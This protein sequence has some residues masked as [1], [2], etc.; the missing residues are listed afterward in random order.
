M[1][2]TQFSSYLG[3][4]LIIENLSDVETEAMQYLKTNGIRFHQ[5]T[6]RWVDR[7]HYLNTPNVKQG[8]LK[9]LMIEC[10]F[11]ERWSKESEL[12]TSGKTFSHIFGL[13]SSPTHTLMIK[14]NIPG[15]CW[16]KIGNATPRNSKV[17]IYLILII[18]LMVR[19]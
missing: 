12:K 10:P 14:R 8:T 9:C 3:L 19:K 7:Q 2:F 13:T 5:K 15:P 1:I 11:S 18:D 4:I 17:H 16:L 6:A